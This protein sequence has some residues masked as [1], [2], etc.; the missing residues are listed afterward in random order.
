MDRILEPRACQGVHYY[1][2]DGDVAHQVTKRT[3]QTMI[4]TV[5]VQ[6][7]A[8]LTVSDLTKGR[9]RSYVESPSNE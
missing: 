3:V 5:V 2:W 6:D 8:L 4:P 9:I 1:T 7:V